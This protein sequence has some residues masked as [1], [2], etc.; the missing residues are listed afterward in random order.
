[1]TAKST[2][3]A[4]GTC[5]LVTTVAGGTVVPSWFEARTTGVATLTLR[6]TAEFGTV[7]GPGASGPFVVTLGARSPS[8]AVI[9]TGRSG[10]R[11]EPGVYRISDGK[12]GPMQALVVTGPVDRPHGVFKARSGTLTISRSR[13]DFIAG[14]FA[15]DAV[16]FEAADP[17]D[18]SKSLR[19]RGTFTATPS[20]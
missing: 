17:A 7:A 12:A 11:P 1:M 5:L 14:T 20:H 4:L 9:F 3:Y 18:E 16:G 8:G 15:L 10:E 13:E 2:L 6:G 19:V